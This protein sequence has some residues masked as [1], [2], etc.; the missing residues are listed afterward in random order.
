MI[1]LDTPTDT[2]NLD[3]QCATN[4]EQHYPPI[5]VDDNLRVSPNGFD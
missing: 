1:L 2:Q 4:H 3:A 5:G